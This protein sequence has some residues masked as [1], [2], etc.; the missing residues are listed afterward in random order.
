MTD[1]V[2]RLAQWTAHDMTCLSRVDA[3]P[4]LRCTCGLDAALDALRQ[5]T[6]AAGRLMWPTAPSRPCPTC[7]HCL[8][9]TPAPPADALRVAR[10]NA[11]GWLVMVEDHH[12]R[13]EGESALAALEAAAR[14]DERAKVRRGFER[15]M[16]PISDDAWARIMALAALDATEGA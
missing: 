6:T 7:G 9:E 15:H 12:P 2:E 8:P 5:E 3:S 14:A 1:R 13:P 4:R 11:R 16:M 10:D